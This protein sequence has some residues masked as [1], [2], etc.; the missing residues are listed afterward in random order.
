MGRTGLGTTSTRC[1]GPLD[2]YLGQWWRSRYWDGVLFFLAYDILWTSFAHY[3]VCSLVILCYFC[4]WVL[5]IWHF[6]VLN[7][8]FFYNRIVLPL[9]LKK[10]WLLIPSFKYS[11]NLFTFWQENRFLVMVIR[12]LL[13]LCE[14]TKGKDNKAVIASNIMW[15]LRHLMLFISNDTNYNATC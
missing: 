11:C 9:F 1:V 14:I 6:D 3:I 15:G 12:D 4:S 10:Y 7:I 13:N 2:L 8:F 5:H